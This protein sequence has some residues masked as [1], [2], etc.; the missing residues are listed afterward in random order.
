MHNTMGR[1]Q[2]KII[3]FSIKG[4]VGG[5]GGGK[6]PLKNKRNMPLR[7]ILGQNKPF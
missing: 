7:S 3:E 5:S 4:W 6:N 1:V 2:K